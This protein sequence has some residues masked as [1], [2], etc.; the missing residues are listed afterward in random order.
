MAAAAHSRRLSSSSSE[1]AKGEGVE[2]PIETVR[3]C[4]GCLAVRDKRE[5]P[6]TPVCAPAEERRSR[7]WSV[8]GRLGRREKRQRIEMSRDE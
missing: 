4:V 7:R 5:R 3:T 6:R 8:K 1:N 2:S